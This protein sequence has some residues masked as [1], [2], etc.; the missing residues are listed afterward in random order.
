MRQ[1]GF[2]LVEMAIGILV[3]GILAVMA[4]AGLSRARASANESAAISALKTINIAQTTYNASCGRGG[5]AQDL[6]VLGQGPQGAGSGYVD[7]ELSKAATVQHHGYRIQM[8]AGQGGGIGNIIDCNNNQT[9]VNYYTSAVPVAYAN[10]GTRSFASNHLGAIWQNTDPTA[11][12]EPFGP[13]SVMV[14]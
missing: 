11:P 14:K 9:L 2:T 8:G 13:P 12:P 5:Y 7:P 10:T 6:T 1:S 4:V 3:M